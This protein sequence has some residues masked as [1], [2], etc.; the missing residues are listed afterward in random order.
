MDGMTFIRFADA[1]VSPIMIAGDLA[2]DL[3]LPVILI[4]AVITAAVLLIRH[5]KSK[6][7]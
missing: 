3:L 5:F 1:L 4:I 2:R 6:K 7:K